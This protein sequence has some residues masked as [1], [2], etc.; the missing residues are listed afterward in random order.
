VV[1]PTLELL[2]PEPMPFRPEQMRMK[3]EEIQKA[4]A[5]KAPAKEVHP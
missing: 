4:R 3:A 1:S 5:S 2:Q